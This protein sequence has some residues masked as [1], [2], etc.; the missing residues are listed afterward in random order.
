VLL[1]L[2]AVAFDKRT[3]QE[4]SLLTQMEVPM[5]PVAVKN[6]AEDIA[7]GLAAAAFLAAI[8][9]FANAMTGGMPV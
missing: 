9:M 1:T 4:H 5:F 8:I 2:F 3:K 7:E 6:I